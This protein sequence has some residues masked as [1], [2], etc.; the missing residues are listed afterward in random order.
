MD[1]VGAQASAG[2]AP[3]P[4]SRKAGLAGLAVF[5]VILVAGLYWA[6]WGPYFQKGFVVAA[7]HTLGASILSG[8]QS[9]PPAP[10]LGAAVSY[11]VSY[12]KAIWIALVAA[13][14]IASGVEALLPRRWLLRLMSGRGA[15]D[16]VLAG[17]LAAPAMMCT[18][19][20][21]PM[22]VSLRRS[23]VPVRSAL[24]WWV[25]NP[26][27]N[28]AVI[29]FAAFILP[30]QFVLL[31]AVAGVVL[32]FVVVALVARLAGSSRVEAPDV[33][34]AIAAY[35]GPS[36][37]ADAARRYFKTLGRLVVTLVPEYLAIVLL[38]GAFRGYLFPIAQGAVGWWGP[39]LVVLFAV[40]GTLFVIPTAGEIPIVQGLLKAGLAVA[41][42]A[43]LLITLPAVS[44]PSL[45]MVWRSFPP[46]V[47]IALAGSVALVGVLTALAA[48]P[49]L[50][51]G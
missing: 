44:L 25:G 24:A 20:S 37:P 30:W 17:V 2:A 38:L 28:P 41:P 29:V 34:Q 48:V 9:A 5:A 10:S 42:A 8:T 11:W 7:H 40:A 3:A 15:V 6:K 32:V 14:L 45:A 13:L 39:L 50:S 49:L 31:R 12:M 1:A 47:T 21:A 19:C 16:G 4:I 51:G 22:A 27:L 33:E 18:C 36:G 23:G 43:A 35:P 26:A 46:R